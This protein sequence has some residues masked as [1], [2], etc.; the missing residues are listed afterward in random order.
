MGCNHHLPRVNGSGDDNFVFVVRYQSVALM[1]KPNHYAVDELNS[2]S[3]GQLVHAYR[4][5]RFV[6]DVTREYCPDLGCIVATSMD[7]R[8]P[9]T[10]FPIFCTGV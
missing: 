8:P 3:N 7:D 10:S 5:R 6:E 1:P 9:T 4:Y 2:E